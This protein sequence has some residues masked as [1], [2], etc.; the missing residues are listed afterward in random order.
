MPRFRWLAHHTSTAPFA[1]AAMASCQLGMTDGRSVSGW[2]RRAALTLTVIAL[3]VLIPTASALAADRVS[4]QQLTANADSE[5]EPHVSGD[6]VVWQGAYKIWTW[7]PTGGVSQLTDSFGAW[8]QVSG[9][10]VVWLGDDVGY[11]K[12][13]LFT[14]T[15]SG[16]VTEIAANSSSMYGGRPQV[17]GDRV[18]WSGWGGSDGGADTEIFTWTPTD[19][20]TQVTVND[21]MDDQPQVSRDRLVWIMEGYP[22]A[23]GVC[24]WTPTHG[25]T[26]LSD[27]G[28]NPQVS[29]DRIVWGDGHGVVAWTPTGGV[30]R[31]SDLGGGPRVSGD[32]VVWIAHGGSDGGTDSEVFTW[33]VAGGVRQ[34]T[35]DASNVY[36]PDVSGDRVVWQRDPDD[37]G[38]NTEVVV[39]TPAGGVTQ[40]SATGTRSGLP[41]VSGD[42]VVWLGKGGT[43]GGDDL[44]V[45]TWGILPN[46]APVAVDDWWVTVED[47]PIPVVPNPTP[48]TANDHDADGDSLT[49]SIVTQADHGTATVGSDGH[50]TYTPPP[51]WFGQTSFT[52]RVFDGTSYSEPAT[53]HINVESVNDPPV[54]VDDHYSVQ[55]DTTLTVEAP[56]VLAT[57]IDVDGD[58]LWVWP[59]RTPVFDTAG[60]R[61][62]SATVNRD[63]SFTYAP[64]PNWTG[65]VMFQ[66]EVRDGGSGY[67]L[68]YTT[69]TIDV[70]PLQDATAPAGSVTINDGATY[71]TA[72]QVTLHLL[73]TDQGSG[74]TRMQ[75]SSDGAVWDSPVPFAET[76]PYSLPTGDGE[77]A[78]YVR[79]SD[80]AGNV[81]DAVSDAIIVDATPPDV[82]ISTPTDDATYGVGEV[83]NADWSASDAGSGLAAS[84][85]T[86]AGGQPLDTTSPGAKSFSVE[87]TDKAGNTARRTV[88]YTVAL[89]DNQVWVPGA[90]RFTSS[91][92]GVDFDF[93]AGALPNLLTVAPVPADQQQSTPSGFKAGPLYLDIS[94]S[95][96]VP[97]GVVVT[98]RY[99]DAGMSASDEDALRLMHWDVGTGEWVDIT[100]GLDTDA[101]EIVGVTDSFSPFALFERDYVETHVDI[102]GEYGD[103]MEDTYIYSAKPDGNFRG[104]TADFVGRTG[105]GEERTVMSIPLSKLAGVTVT[106]ATLDLTKSTGGPTALRVY[107]LRH[108]VTSTT[109]WN[110]FRAGSPWAIAGAKGAG[111][112]FVATRYAESTGD[113]FDVGPLL[114]DALAE[115]A[116]TLDL[117]IVDPTPVEKRYSGFYSAECVK[118]EWRPCLEVEGTRPLP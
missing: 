65:T 118:P 9:D 86:V 18:V 2:S 114:Q 93:P 106:G 36:A 94:A 51:N 82:T 26:R 22:V 1:T 41:K 11:D 96:P 107:R 38:Y 99:D 16:G 110:A 49:A 13:K 15:P 8:P 63:G 72:S 77:R 58:A 44:E 101:N 46:T 28:S 57:D 30:T 117:V 88:T 47:R 103:A 60:E 81:S 73:A 39:W 61:Q 43:D 48:L 17:S 33:T 71:A 20:V 92:G 98:L 62:G 75:F 55:Q 69:V 12:F 109:S 23:M 3:A 6:R 35:S 74:V 79:F 87:A 53:V 19:G 108:A 32:R 42:R 4:T 5:M 54:G 29:G 100:T 104:S 111:S 84:S 14:W 91:D 112:D 52:Y 64:P 83:V 45:F 10:R 24:T 116:T 37:G 21:V 76:A 50:F 56:G 40:L 25:V 115:G 80:G 31:L 27:G 105:S 67:E 95:G 90:G 68:T 89:A 102:G 59:G 78:V 97:R 85:G 66:Y 34:L 70:T 7:T 113:D